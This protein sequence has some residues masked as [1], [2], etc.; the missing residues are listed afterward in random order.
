M[1]QGVPER[2]DVAIVFFEAAR[3]PVTAVAITY[4]V[5]VI[6]DCRMHCGFK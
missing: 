6:T 4:E 2:C 5:Q 1:L 3:E